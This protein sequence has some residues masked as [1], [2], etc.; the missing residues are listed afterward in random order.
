[1][2]TEIDG[3]ELRKECTSTP[4]NYMGYYDDLYKAIT[5]KGPNPVPGADALKTTRIIETALRSAAEGKVIS[6]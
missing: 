1:L 6:L 5:G 3:K 4:G 2:H